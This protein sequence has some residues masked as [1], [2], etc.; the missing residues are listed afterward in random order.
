MLWVKWSFVLIVY[1]IYLASKTAREMS[2]ENAN[3][4]LPE[5]Q[6]RKYSKD[7]NRELCPGCLQRSNSV[8]A[9]MSHPFSTN[10]SEQ[11]FPTK[12]VQSQ[13]GG[14]DDII[15]QQMTAVFKTS[16]QRSYIM[17]LTLCNDWVYIVFIE[18]CGTFIFYWWTTWFDTEKPR[19]STSIESKLLF[20]FTTLKK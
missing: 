6:I 3:I 1:R 15:N 10:T 18:E 17:S 16:F 14:K 9:T 7:V 11:L 12:Y 19:Y 4:T 20:S 13:N 2:F 8:P 5:I